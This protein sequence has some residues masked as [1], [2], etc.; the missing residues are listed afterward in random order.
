MLRFF[1]AIL[2]LYM[3]APTNA[4]QQ[5]DYT[6][7]SKVDHDK[8][9][10]TQGFYLEGTTLYESSGLY[11]RSFIRMYEE[12]SNKILKHQSL[13]PSIFAEGLTKFENSLYLLTWKAGQM[14]VFDA[15]SLDHKK[16][17]RYQGEGWGLTH[18]E[19]D[20]IMSNGSMV[21]TFL[22]PNNLKVK[23]N[24]KIKNSPQVNLRI[25]ELEYVDGYVWA[26]AWTNN[27]IFKINA[28]NGKVEAYA[29]FSAIVKENATS[30]NAVLNGIAF[31]KTKNAFWITGKNWPHRYLI[32]FTDDL[33][34][35]R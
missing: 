21:L 33:A 18:N 27:N 3:V 1:C 4:A 20:L 14:W 30:A 22:D 5:L 13:P 29:N 28:A 12:S 11:H 6:I 26:N 7:L 23:R 31:D 8:N 35:S 15:K 32:K 34:S 16:T 24:I 9:S 10:F 25:N 2:L 19:T 17:M